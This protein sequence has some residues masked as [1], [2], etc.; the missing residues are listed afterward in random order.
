MNIDSKRVLI[1]GGAGFIGSNFVLRTLERYPHA[2]LYN[3]DKLTYAANPRGMERAECSGRYQLIRAD[4]AHGETMRT[5]FERIEPE[6]IIHFAAESHVDRSILGP[7]EFIR[8]NIEGTFQLLE[9]ARALH[10]ASKPIHFHHISTDE[11]YGSLPLDEGAF[12]ESTAYDP[13]SPYSA[14]KAASDHLVR[15]YYRT[16]GLPITITNCTN[17]YGPRQFPEKL[18]PLMILSALEER[19]LPIYGEGKNVRDW[20]YV[21]DHIE[22]IWAAIE[23]GRVG[24]TYGIGGGEEKNNLEVVECIAQIVAAEADMD[25]EAILARRVFI[26]D[27]PGHDLRYA[28]D[29]QKARDELGWTPRES[30]ESGMR[31]TVRYILENRALYDSI[32]SGEYRQWIAKNYTKRG[33]EAA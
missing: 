12:T 19:S 10:T 8:T 23:R 33:G 14:S 1:T 2:K 13:S 5:L 22:A 9:A 26:R 18:V 7:A 30:F 3:V 20:L 31:K 29:P 4:I 28:I 32:R 25:A 6:L 11:V 16:Y 24:E 17:N 21:D 15:A 27:R